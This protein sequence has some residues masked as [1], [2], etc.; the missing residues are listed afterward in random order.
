VVAPGSWAEDLLLGNRDPVAFFQMYPTGWDN[1]CSQFNAPSSPG[2]ITT[3]ASNIGL[4]MMYYDTYVVQY[5]PC[6]D[7]SHPNHNPLLPA[8]APL[9][10]TLETERQYRADLLDATRAALSAVGSGEGVAPVWAIPHLDYFEGAM[11]LRTYG[12]A[13]SHI[14]SGDY[15]NDFA[16][17]TVPPPPGLS[18]DEQHRIPLFELMFHDHVVSTWNW[19]NTN[20]QS[21]ATSA[22]KDLFNALYG[23]MPMWNV[24]TD[25]WATYGQMYLDSYA[26]QK[27]SRSVVGFD[28]MIGHGWLSTDRE[29]QYT[30]WASGVRIIANFDS[31]ARDANGVTV[32]ALD[33]VIVDSAQG[34]GGAGGSG[35][36]GDGAGGATGHG[37]ASST[38]GAGAGGPAAT[39][40]GAGGGVTSGDGGG[41]ATGATA[42]PS[43]DGD[44]GASSGGCS[45]SSS[46]A[47]T[48]APLA[49]LGL[50]AALAARRRREARPRR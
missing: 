13:E 3:L 26:L 7:A 39:T 25:H 19:R 16:P 47:F 17:A 5:A 40:T 4:Q 36:G 12:E 30:D 22:K 43:G 48:E 8:P 27:R 10:S 42:A 14:P 37:G 35:S 46:R 18:V 20:F 2:D 1:S 49:L 38:A 15:N 28:D 41:G 11:M 29:V 21:L 6:L 33:F 31:V 45:A 23:T 32:P 9:P 24:T 44:A 50:V 34:G